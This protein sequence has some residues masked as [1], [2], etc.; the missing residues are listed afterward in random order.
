MATLVMVGACTS[1]SSTAANSTSTSSTT[2][3]ATTLP[4]TSTTIPPTTTK[5]AHLEPSARWS[6]DG[7]GVAHGTNL[8]GRGSL[9]LRD[10]TNVF[11]ADGNG[12][13]TALQLAT[14]EQLWQQSVEGGGVVLLGITL[15]SVVVGGYGLVVALDPSTGVE[16]WRFV[17]SGG[18]WP[19]AAYE[20]EHGVHVLLDRPT[21]GD[22][23][24]PVVMTFDRTDGS[25]IW[26]TTLDGVDHPDLDLQPGP[27]SSALVGDRLFVKT[28][29][30]M[31]ALNARTGA[32]VWIHRFAAVPHERYSPAQLLVDGELLYVPDPNGELVA[33]EADTGRQRW[34]LEVEP[35]FVAP[36]S[37]DRHLVFVD[38]A[39]VHAADTVTGDRVWDQAFADTRTQAAVVGDVVVALGGRQLTGL[40]V[41]TGNPLWSAL[42]D[43]EIAY[44][45]LAAG[46]VAVAA[47]EDGV[48]AVRADTGAIL[49]ELDRGVAEPP[50]IVDD[51]ILLAHPDDHR[52]I[53]LYPVRPD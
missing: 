19:L 50:L 16:Q 45:V 51:S 25:V 30:A 13:V 44:A 53:A 26:S 9:V 41:A 47:A 52:T 46:D 4:T 2:L 42:V 15:E 18:L 11:V 31:H 20:G 5:P 17:P 43:L 48:V 36:V 14:G 10:V 28:T 29:G 33:L 39:G 27:S 1:G 3:A 24:P 22:N 6:V 37:I 7:I 34:R 35:G 40:D 38:G 8:L 21:E 12:M 32:I 49:W 23:E